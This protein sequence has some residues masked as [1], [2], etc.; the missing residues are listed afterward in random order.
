M[1]IARSAELCGSRS[2]DLVPDLRGSVPESGDIEILDTHVSCCD[3]QPDPTMGSYFC[4][5]K[6]TQRSSGRRIQNTLSSS[7]QTSINLKQFTKN[8]YRPTQGKSCSMNRNTSNSGNHATLHQ[9]ASI[10]Q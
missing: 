8:N 2:G 4:V 9:L 3:G 7:S 10:M 6:A 1:P 5:I